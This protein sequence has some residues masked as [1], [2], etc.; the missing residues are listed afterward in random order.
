MSNDDPLSTFITR[1]NLTPKA[2][3]ELSALAG[4]WRRGW[5][6]GSIAALGSG[7]WGAETGASETS[8]PATPER[9]RIDGL[10]G[11]GGMGRVYK[12][13]DAVLGR[14]VAL[15]VLR[16][17]LSINDRFL[18]RFGAEA[19]ATAQLTHPGIVPV[20][21][22]GELPDGRR[23]FT[24]EVVEGRTLGQVFDDDTLSLR[25]KVELLRRAAE[26]V[27][28]A[29]SRQ[30]LHRDIKPANVMV[31][32]FGQVKVLDW[33]L[34][35]VGD[36]SLLDPSAPGTPGMTRAGE[37]SGTPAYMPPEQARGESV[38]TP[39]DVF[40]LGAVLYRLLHQ[41]SPY[42]E[43]S[44]DEILAQLRQNQTPAP[45]QGPLALQA[46]CAQAL[47]AHPL[48]RP[49]DA[50]AFVS[51]L[52][53][54]L[55]DAQAQA[56]AQV[57]L[58]EAQALKGDLEDLQEKCRDLERLASQAGHGLK[59][60]TPTDSKR[61][62][63]DLED[64]ID[65]LTQ[66]TQLAEVQY[67]NGVRA[68]LNEADL[69]AAHQALADHY[70][71]QHQD[72]ER[73][74]QGAQAAR[75]LEL[76]KIHDRGPH[77]D[78][79]AGWG[80]LDLDTEPRGATVTCFRYVEEE[81]RLVP[82]RV[83]VL[84]QTPIQGMRLEHGSYLLRIESPLREVLE[85]PVQIERGQRWRNLPPEDHPR[86]DDARVPLHPLG[87]LSV[88]E[89][90]VPAGWFR[91]G[92]PL[93][94]DGLPRRQVWVDDCAIGRVP[95]TNLDYIEW[96]DELVARGQEEQA[97]SHA[98][99]SMAHAGDSK[100]TLYY[101]RK[102]D[103]RFELVPDEQGDVWGLQWPVL[104]ISAISARD[105]AAWKGEQMG[106]ALRLPMELEREKA[107]RGVDG[108]IFSWGDSPQATYSTNGQARRGRAVPVDVGSCPTDVS[109]YGLLDGCGNVRD[110]CLDRRRSEHPLLLGQWAKLPPATLSKAERDDP[111][112]VDWGVLR[113]GL[114]SGGI[115]LCR[116]GHRSFYPLNH[117]SSLMGVRLARSLKG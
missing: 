46:L 61:A 98:P 20:F 78:Y 62:L 84:G 81:R 47:Q 66:Q 76:L 110:A 33:G 99:R 108:R 79:L 19:R 3:E 82:K 63:W 112:N 97:L 73:A 56:R 101:G 68:A 40:A 38:S 52:A 58:E 34:V 113:G 7:V 39:A 111:S 91:S 57:R 24:M 28:F 13:H 89:V 42:T 71:E 26:A 80:W 6:G 85:L 54:W 48:D 4:D 115:H 12:A 22:L 75:S 32:R 16:P 50:G 21:E 67:I 23:F 10:L 92:D 88:S 18:E 117:R 83:D 53:E 35:R 96:L 100:G 109:P 87:T 74:H 45:S 14:I 44:G 77:Q 60:W 95:V 9:Y 103:G 105:Y 86:A 116:S 41:A 64:Q 94:K 31:G 114:W 106:Q 51:A 17:E 25:R 1:H 93:A 5:Q 49:K 104:L 11:Q 55:E 102:T 90:R 2:A 36:H 72:A 27:A 29:H 8:H 15:K 43:Q 30:V 37:V 70:R 65:I 107:V 69:D 59:S